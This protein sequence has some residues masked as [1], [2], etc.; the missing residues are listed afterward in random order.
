MVRPSH[1]C[2]GAAKEEERG[3]K[4][5]GKKWGETGCAEECGGPTGEGEEEHRSES[6]TLT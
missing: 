3:S 5:E 2:P 1:L 4:R 6:V